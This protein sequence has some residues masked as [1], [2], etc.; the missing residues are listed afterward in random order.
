MNRL[1]SYWASILAD[2]AEGKA[3]LLKNNIVQLLAQN[4]N[5]LSVNW[6]KGQ[7]YNTDVD[8]IQISFSIQVIVQ[9]PIILMP[10][11]EDIFLAT[12]EAICAKTDDNILETIA[13]RLDDFAQCTHPPY[14]IG[15]LPTVQLTENMIVT[16]FS[17]TGTATETAKR[18]YGDVKRLYFTE[19][20]R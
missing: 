1:L 8:Q 17:F 15:L 3:Q 10:E 4:S 16:Q 14:K 7:A 5:I 9:N 2:L 18:E 6:Q 11:S 12:F 13:A 19:H 20:Q